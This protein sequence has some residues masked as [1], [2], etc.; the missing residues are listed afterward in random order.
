MALG[1]GVL[2]LQPEVSYLQKGVD[3]LEI[4]YVEAAAL[5]KVGVPIIPNVIPHAFAGIGADYQ[6][7]EN[8]T[9][10]VST[11]ELDWNALFGADVFIAA[12]GLALI[13]DIRYAVG[14][15]DIHDTGDAIGDFKNRAWLVSAGLGFVF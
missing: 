10:P 12:G 5:L 6:V 4:D 13:A 3:A 1:A 8:T 2:S 11:D 15:K 14:L 7:D 9:L